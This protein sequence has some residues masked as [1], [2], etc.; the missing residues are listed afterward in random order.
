MVNE[1]AEDVGSVSSDRVTYTLLLTGSPSRVP[2]CRDFGLRYERALELE[3]G[4][5]VPY[6]NRGVA[7]SR[8]DLPL[9]HK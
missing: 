1:R 2:L 7:L 5:A 9:P 8:G 4:N 6:A 3:D